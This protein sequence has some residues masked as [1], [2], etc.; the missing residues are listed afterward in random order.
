MFTSYVVTN[1]ASTYAFV[2]ILAM[3]VV[4]RA[5]YTTCTVN[6][7]ME[8]FARPD[9]RPLAAGSALNVDHMSASTVQAAV[10]VATTTPTEPAPVCEPTA[11]VTT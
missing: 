6:C 1:S 2:G 7:L 11:T 10:A 9:N 8:I 3:V 4:F 5:A